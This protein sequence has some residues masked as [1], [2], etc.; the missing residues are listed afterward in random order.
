MNMEPVTY[1]AVPKR[2]P[3][4]PEDAE[5]IEAVTTCT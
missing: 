4:I 1:D 2:D 5:T 3:V